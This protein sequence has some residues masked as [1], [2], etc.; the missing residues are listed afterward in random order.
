M[1]F[2]GKFY[3]CRY[4]PLLS[5]R[6]LHDLLAFARTFSEPWL[7][8]IQVEE[9]DCRSDVQLHPHIDVAR[10]IRQSRVIEPKYLVDTIH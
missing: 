5:S 3:K 9:D 8:E 6:P 2:Q 4:H 1:H 10:G 7:C